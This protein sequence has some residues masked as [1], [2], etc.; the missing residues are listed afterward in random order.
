ME[1]KKTKGEELAEQLLYKTK[2]AGETMSAEEIAK[3]DAFCEPYK[4]FLDT[5][6]TEREATVTTIALLEK[7]GYKPFDPSVKY[8]AG[9]KVYRNIRGKALIFATMGTQPLEEGVRFLISHIDSPRLDLKPNPLYEEAGIALFK[10]HYYGGVK[11]YQWGALPLALHGVVI[12]KDGTSL[13]VKIG[14]EPGDPLFCVTDLLP[15]LGKDQMAR[16]LKEGLRGEELNILVGS[17]PFED[18]K[19]SDK[20]K[21]N[22]LRLLNEKYGLIEADFLSAELTMVPSQNAC[23]VGFDRSMIG[24]YAHDDKVCAYTSLMAAMEVT[25]PKITS[26]TVFADKE[27]VGSEGNTGL[28]SDFVRYFIEDLCAPH[29]IPARTVLTASQCLSADVN[30]AFDP[31]FPDVNEKRNTAFLNRGVVITKYTGSGGKG[32]TNDASAEFVGRVRRILDNAGVIWQTGE[33]GKVDFG[34]GGTVA[35]FVA[36]MGVEVVD[37]GVPVLS[38]HAPFEIVSKTDVY[39]T[40]R[41]FKEFLLAE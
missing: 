6:K 4:S 33:L 34:G 15:H 8:Q 27:E 20:V 10:T 35:K 40:Y 12:K 5:A 18:K 29:G 11:K 13:T 3:A 7:N 23:D 36:Y 39:S 38:M 41:A 31:T 2:D 26:V 1:E 37:L 14:D 22:I 28:D 30:C 16:T 19:V 25:A 32:G 9:E 24:A 17:R 21:L